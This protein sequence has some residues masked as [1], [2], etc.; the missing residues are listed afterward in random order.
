[1][2]TRPED[3]SS[4]TAKIEAAFRQAAIGIVARARQT[5]TPVI[6]WRN[7]RVEAIPPEQFPTLMPPEERPAGPQS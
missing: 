6:V 1:M 7:G 2:I 5:G 3:D 4:I